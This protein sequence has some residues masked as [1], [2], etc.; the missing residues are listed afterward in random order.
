MKLSIQTSAGAY[1]YNLKT[2]YIGVKKINKKIAKENLL[3]FKS[4]MDK[5][6]ISFGLIYGTLLGAI[7]ENDFISHDED[8][9]LY[10]LEEN[11]ELFLEKLFY[12]RKHG[13]EV[14][15]YDKRGLLSIIRNGEYIDIY[16]FSKFKKGVRISSGLCVEE[17][18]LTNTTYLN[19]MGTSFLAPKE[20]IRFLEFEYGKSWKTPIPYTDFKVS[21]KKIMMFKIKEH[22]K[23]LLPDFMYLR[24]IKI[25]ERKMIQ[26][27]EEKFTEESMYNENIPHH[28]HV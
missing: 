10:M 22:F 27:F 24:L 12:L 20:S 19:F 7:R 1:Y 13:F 11:K 17:S 6:N 8:I 28:S 5:Q 23:Y 2:L 3:L 18:Y 16:F 9:D 25:N 21:S 15:R 4:L 26:D 14:A